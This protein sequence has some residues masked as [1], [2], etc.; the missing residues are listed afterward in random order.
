MDMGF[1]RL[2]RIVPLA[3]FVVSPSLWA[4]RVL[5][6]DGTPVRLRLKGDLMA[7]RVAQGDRVDYEVAQPLSVQGLVAIPAG[8][9]AWGAV[10]SS[11]PDKEIKFDI[12]GLRLPSM[13][14]IKLR[15]VREKTKNP[16]KDIIKVETKFGSGVGALRGSE[17]T[18]YVDEEVYVEALASQ[19]AAS[20]PASA[21]APAPA[22]L[23]AASSAPSRTTASPAATT[24]AIPAPTAVPATSQPE[25]SSAASPI[26]PVTDRVTVECF[27]T[28][29][30]AEIYIDGDFY[31]HTPSILKLTA[32]GHR[33][34]IRLSD[35]RTYSE[36]LNLVPGM[37]LRTIRRDLEKK[38]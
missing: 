27:S 30:G 21:P 15:S 26:A 9:V 12:Q 37:G 36:V 38:E 20:K 3:L 28:P 8:A 29:S 18:G 13:Q 5:I 10:Q 14:E 24:V 32:T 31:G 7:S 11:K 23:T 6:R 4:E 35:H 16:G 25:P 34:E 22:S 2:V 33:L 19:P 17:F 1:R